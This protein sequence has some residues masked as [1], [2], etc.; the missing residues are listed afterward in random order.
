MYV[1]VFNGPPRSGKDTCAA[2]L[3]A[4]M[5]KSVVTPVKEESLSYPLRSIACAMVGW[6]YDDSTYEDFKVTYFPQFDRT[7]RELMID[8]SERFLKECYGQQIMARMLVER[9][10]GFDGLLLIRDGGFQCEVDVLINSYGIDQVY[11]VRVDRPGT[12]FDGDSRSWVNH[13][14]S[15]NSMGLPNYTDLKDLHTE[16]L[17][18]YGR[19]LNQMG[20]RL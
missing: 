13:P 3:A 17:R 11:V 2:M 5:D 12:S 8:V 19:L 10:A 15:R 16:V 1:V 14:K 9:N 6:E 18:V 20:W 7:G 4:H